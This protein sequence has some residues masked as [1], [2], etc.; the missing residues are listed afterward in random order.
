MEMPMAFVAELQQSPTAENLLSVD[1][2]DLY[3][4]WIGGSACSTL[5]IYVT[6]WQF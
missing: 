4:G 5:N 2:V 1:F 6:E 3:K